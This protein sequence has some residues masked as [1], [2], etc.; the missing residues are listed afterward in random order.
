MSE[1]CVLC[2]KKKEKGEEQA[3]KKKEW[4]EKLAEKQANSELAQIKFLAGGVQPV[5]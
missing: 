1:C 2:S 3:R 5:D 4:E